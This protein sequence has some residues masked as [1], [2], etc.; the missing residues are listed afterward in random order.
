MPVPL[1]PL[2][3]PTQKTTHTHNKKQQQQKQH[4]HNTY[5]QTHTC[6][7]THTHT[8][9]IHTS[10]HTHAHNTH[11]HTHMHARTHTTH[12]HTHAHTQQN[13]THTHTHT[14][15]H[16]KGLGERRNGF[17]ERLLQASSLP[18]CTLVR[19]MT[20]GKKIK[21]ESKSTYFIERQRETKVQTMY[22]HDFC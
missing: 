8:Q 15:T 3:Y 6:T 9:H 11:T 20:E 19:K 5:T 2:H 4:T 14:H 12:A 21:Q 1:D 17:R 7:H 18:C 16:N 10:T 13:T 22:F